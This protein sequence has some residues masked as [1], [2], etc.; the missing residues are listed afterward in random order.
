M[1]D[2]L[3]ALFQSLAPLWEMSVTAAYASAIV[4]VLRLLLKKRAPRQVLCLLWLVVFARL[5]IPVTLESPLSIV[6]SALPGQEQQT[7]L[8]NTPQA[9]ARDSIQGQPNAGTADPVTNDPAEPSLAIPGNVTPAAL[10]GQPEQTGSPWQAVIAGVW[11]AGAIAMGGY[12]LFSYLRLRRRLF[13]AIRARDGAWEHPDLDSPFILGVFRP[14]IYLPAGLVGQPRQFILCHERAHL[15]RLDHIVKPL[16]WAALALHWFN[17]LVWASFILMS[18]DIESACDEAVV[19]QLGSGV[20][21]DYSTT[22]LALATGRRA[23][24][25]CPLAFDEGDAKGRIKNVLGYRR[26]A[27]WVIV[28]SVTAAVLAAACLLTDPVAAE[29]PDGSPDAPASPTPANVLADTLLDPWMKEVLDGERNFSTTYAFDNSR[30]YS[31]NDLRSFYYGDGQLPD[32]RVEMGR[33]AIVDLDR[34]GINEMVIFPVGDNEYLY[35]V[36]GYLILHRVG[37]EV[38]GYAPG[39]RSC[40][41]IKSDGTFTWSSDAADWG[42]SSMSFNSGELV[43]NDITWCSSIQG[44]DELY[45]VDGLKATREEFDAAYDAHAAKPEPV[46]Y[47]YAGGVLDVWTDDAGMRTLDKTIPETDSG[48]A[49]LWLDDAEQFWLE[50]NGTT[51]LLNSSISSE[52]FSDILCRDFDGDG[53]NEVVLTY[54]INGFPQLELYEWNGD[55]PVLAGSYDTQQLLLR[56]NQ[57]NVAGYNKDTRGLTVTYSHNERSSDSEDYDRRYVTGSATLPE[58]F[59]DRYEH[60]RD[61]YTH[62]YANQFSLFHLVDDAQI[63]NAF[64]FDFDFYLSD[65]TM[66][67]LACV[68]TLLNSDYSFHYMAG[69]PVGSIHFTLSYDGTG[70]R[71]EAADALDMGL[72]GQPLQP[73]AAIDA[74]APLDAPLIPMGS[75]TLAYMI[76]LPDDPSQWYKVAELPEDEIYM[77]SRDHG[78]ETLLRW[79]KSA[80]KV[81]SHTAHTPSPDSASPCMKKLGGADTYGPLAVINHVGNDRNFAIY[82]L[83]IYALDASGLTDHT[84]D[85]RPLM[86]DFNANCSYRFDE[87]GLTLAYQGQTLEMPREEFLEETYR[88]I[89]QEGL[90]LRIT[91]EMV[92]QYSFAPENSGNIDIMLG[93]EAFIGDHSSYDFIPCDAIW[94]LR[95]NGSG[96][97]TVPGSF[98]FNVM[99]NE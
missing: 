63:H 20:K 11:L 42:I 67:E 5:L 16:C 72:E 39:W 69:K 59:F 13:D 68:D 55:T 51:T 71:V 95:F 56:F 54:Q 52:Q 1:V 58:G 84:Y 53:E 30:T 75:S 48:E 70:W 15:R 45:F 12:A 41:Y 49:V 90:D 40:E 81:F 96:F 31:I 7:V 92:V 62:A 2:R 85:W 57:S 28:V 66:Q 38:Y 78:K 18:R 29:A 24:S 64:S 73:A 88:K 60:I 97:D 14:R 33:L 25:P 37:D 32:E 46:W 50:W 6:P 35:S 99:N 44:P 9:P 17:P 74:A 43:N 79:G 89:L 26:P 86:E 98:H 82:D 22:L 4:M 61:G 19:R 93:V 3:S 80:Y 23:P 65:E 76:G 77:F 34:D 21:A 91:G 10:P 83:R 47:T 8:P 94:T 27:L 87:Q 36:V